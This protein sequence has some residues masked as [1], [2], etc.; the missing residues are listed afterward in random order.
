MLPVPHD[1]CFLSGYLCQHTAPCLVN[2]CYKTAAFCATDGS[3]FIL[4]VSH[5]SC[6][7]LLTCANRQLL[8][9]AYLCRTTAVLFF[10]TCATHQM[11]IFAHLWQHDICLSLL[12]C[13]TRQLLSPLCTARQHFVSVFYLCH[14]AAV[15][16]CLPVPHNSCLNMFP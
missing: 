9:F 13:A 11:L 15:C 4:P 1:S 8:I 12:T 5:G 6:L 16:H 2:L 10:L 7:S 3:Y 14:K